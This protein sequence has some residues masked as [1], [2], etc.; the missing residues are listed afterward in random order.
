MIMLIT[1]QRL[2]QKVNHSITLMHLLSVMV[3][4]GGVNCAVKS[5]NFQSKFNELPKLHL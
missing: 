4:T 3:S 1:D 2:M 5:I